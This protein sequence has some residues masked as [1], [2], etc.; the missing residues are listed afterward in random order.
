[1]GYR[2]CD[3]VVRWDGRTGYSLPLIEPTIT[4][5]GP[6]LISAT[7]PASAADSIASVD[8]SGWPLTDVANG[9]GSDRRRRSR[10][11]RRRR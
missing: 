9:S 4:A 1:M 8:V 6:R 7:S 5:P 3:V 10:S 11:A 2:R